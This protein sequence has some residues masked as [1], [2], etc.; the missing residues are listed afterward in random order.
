VT[1]HGNFTI[2][3]LIERHRDTVADGYS[4]SHQYGLRV[5]LE[6]LSQPCGHTR[7]IA[8]GPFAPRTAW[9][10]QIE[11]NLNDPQ[12]DSGQQGRVVGADA[13]RL[14]SRRAS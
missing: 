9:R 1:L 5:V 4:R 12:S 6:V 13:G 11:G 7:A 10:A 14:L 8:A 2:D 3:E